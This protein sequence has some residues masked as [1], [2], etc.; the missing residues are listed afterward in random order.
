MGRIL[1]RLCRF[2]EAISSLLR[3]TEIQPNDATAFNNLGIVLS[4]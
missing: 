3:L 1:K 4:E 2:D